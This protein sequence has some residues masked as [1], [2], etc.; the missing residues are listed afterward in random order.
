[1]ALAPSLLARQPRSASPLC[2]ALIS[3][4]RSRLP[5]SSWHSSQ[6]SVQTAELLRKGDFQAALESKEATPLQIL[7]AQLGLEW[8]G[9]T[10]AA[11]GIL[12]SGDPR[13]SLQ[14]QHMGLKGVDDARKT[15][16]RMR[17]ESLGTE[18]VQKAYKLVFFALTHIHADEVLQNRGTHTNS[19]STAMDLYQKMKQDGLVVPG[20]VI[21]FLV[22]AQKRRGNWRSC[23]ELLKDWMERHRD[24][25]DIPPPDLQTYVDVFECLNASGSDPPDGLSP[26][27]VLVALHHLYQDMIIKGHVPPHRLY[28][29]LL[30]RIAL[31]GEP[32]LLGELVRQRKDSDQ[33]RAPLSFDSLFAHTQ[34]TKAA[35]VFTQLR[36]AGEAD[37][38]CYV[39]FLQRL[40]KEQ[41]AETGLVMARVLGWLLEDLDGGSLVPSV[42]LWEVLF[43]ALQHRAGEAQLGELLRDLVSWAHTEF[44]CGSGTLTAASL[45]SLFRCLAQLTPA[46]HTQLQDPTTLQ[47]L[48]DMASSFV[49]G[50]VSDP[51]AAGSQ[52]KVQQ[53]MEILKNICL[54]FT[55]Q[56]KILELLQHFDMMQASG[57]DFVRVLCA[58]GHSNLASDLWKSGIRLRSS[59]DTKT[60]TA[61]TTYTGQQALDEYAADCLLAYL[62]GVIDCCKKPTAQRIEDV[63]AFADRLIAMRNSRVLRQEF[64]F[65]SWKEAERGLLRALV[66][67]SLLGGPSPQPLS[68]RSSLHIIP[69]D[70]FLMKY[71]EL[72]RAMPR[73]E[74]QDDAAEV[75]L[76]HALSQQNKEVAA[77]IVT[78]LGVQIDRPL[79]DGQNFTTRCTNREMKNVLT[80]AKDSQ[81]RLA[82]AVRL[83]S[84]PPL[85]RGRS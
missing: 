38:D 16:D 75:A 29:M 84:K 7:Q 3:Y 80:L 57:V 37:V 8:K 76:C 9:D 13:Q 65:S 43:A 32:F 30:M 6:F 42:Q 28:E 54:F 60:T 17:E 59:P 67:V 62:E 49:A 27:D 45:G 41:G 68:E 51:A 1:M 61:Q 83:P 72:L 36:L 12:D 79:A 5:R 73:P 74:G 4:K 50:Q 44:R 81:T 78:K 58:A 18:E 56:E 14:A 15:L 85:G 47:L 23:S 20:P 24:F 52:D 64:G 19:L 34:L 48:S 63:I 82:A 39:C 11:R 22:A 46:Y 33:P 77:T 26:G 53:H 31:H 35:E 40:S 70:H 21:N 25:P 10:Q 71:I 69:H 66:K 2:R 55:E